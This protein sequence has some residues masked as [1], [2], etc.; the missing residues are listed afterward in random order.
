MLS[1]ELDSLHRPE[2][3]PDAQSVERLGIEPKKLRGEALYLALHDRRRFRRPFEDRHVDVAEL[4][5]RINALRTL[6][7]QL[8]CPPETAF[9]L[10]EPVLPDLCQAIAVV[11]FPIARVLSDRRAVHD[12]SL[13][14]FLLVKIPVA[15]VEIFFL[16]DV[17]IAAA[18]G[19]NKS[20]RE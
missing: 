2:G 18:A 10:A 4:D 11:C 6:G 3:A 14:I 1:R 9:G 19:G 16:E 15:R 5:P 13:A 7:Q 12:G 8:D 17:R 20:S